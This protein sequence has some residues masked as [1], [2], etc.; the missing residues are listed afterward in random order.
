MKR[1]QGV[2]DPNHTEKRENSYY[3]R[4]ALDAYTMKD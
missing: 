4:M 3:R 1:L 2:V